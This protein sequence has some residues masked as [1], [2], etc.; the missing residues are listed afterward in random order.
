MKKVKINVLAILLI[1]LL[2]LIFCNNCCNASVES[3]TEYGEIPSSLRGASNS[4]D[5]TLSPAQGAGLIQT[6]MGSI[7]VIVQLL[8]IFISALLIFVSIFK[9]LEHRKDD[10]SKKYKMIMIICINIAIVLFAASGILGIIRTFADKP[11]IYI[12][13]E[14]ETEVSVTLGKEELI[15]CSYPK[16]D[17]GWKVLAKP[18]GDLVDLKTGKF[19]ETK[20]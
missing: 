2:F 17:N 14:T 4:Y 19:Q 13:P 8:G 18:N 7:L 1:S 3:N 5:T 9:Y 10:N 6:W 15:D 16:Y 11:I 12:Y 20:L